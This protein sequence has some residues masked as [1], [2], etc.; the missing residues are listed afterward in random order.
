MVKEKSWYGFRSLCAS[1][2]WVSRGVNG[3]VRF[4]FFEKPN[5]TEPLEKSSEPKPKPKPNRTE[6]M[7]R[8]GSVFRFSTFGFRFSLCISL[9]VY[10]SLYL[11][12]CPRIKPFEE[13]KRRL[14]P[15]WRLELKTSPSLTPHELEAESWLNQ[16]GRIHYSTSP[17]RTDPNPILNW[18]FTARIAW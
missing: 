4:G 10:L 5:R 1:H 16:T 9:S 17:R 18:R 8:F 3:S 15:R 13:G 11:S 14:K 2:M 12:L 6:P 7:V